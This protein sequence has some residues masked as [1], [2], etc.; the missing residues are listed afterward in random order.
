MDILRL[1]KNA[2]GAP[3]IERLGREYMEE[4][5]MT[6]KPY[7]FCDHC[8]THGPVPN[9]GTCAKLNRPNPQTAK[10]LNDELNRLFVCHDASPRA[11]ME[12]P[13]VYDEKNQ[14]VYTK[15]VVYRLVGLAGQEKDCVEEMWRVL[16]HVQLMGQGGETLLVRRRFEFDRSFEGE[17]GE[18]RLVG[19]VAFWNEVMNDGLARYGVVITD[20]GAPRRV[21]PK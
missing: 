5:G 14:P 2:F 7:R 16:R 10:E 21:A 18:G 15:R 12:L 3:Y 6:V 17:K 13:M 9:C 11:Y 1:L 19:R 8:N 20:G 4:A